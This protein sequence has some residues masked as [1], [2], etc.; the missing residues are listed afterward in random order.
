M[1][2]SLLLL[3]LA[4]CFSFDLLAQP[5]FIKQ[6]TLSSSE[7]N[8]VHLPGTGSSLLV[9][10]AATTTS[11]K[12]LA[13]TRLDS[14]GTVSG[15]T[16]WDGSNTQGAIFNVRPLA[17]GRLMACGYDFINFSDLYGLLVEIDATG[18]P[19]QAHHLGYNSV[20]RWADVVAT[21]D[22]GFIALG[23]GSVQS[24]IDIQSIFA[25]FDAQGDTVWTH[26]YGNSGYEYQLV[27]G[28]LLPQ[29]D[30]LAFGTSLVIGSNRYTLTAQSMSPS[31]HLRWAKRY[32]T[33]AYSLRPGAAVVH[34]DTVYLAFSVRD[35]SS[36]T[37]VETA[38]MLAMDTTG[39]VLWA[40]LLAGQDASFA[41]Q[42]G[43]T[44]SGEPI[45]VGGY[46]RGTDTYGL[47]AAFSSSGSLLW[48]S[49][50]GVGNTVNSILDTDDGYLLAIADELVSQVMHVARVGTQGQLSSNCDTEI[51]SWAPTPLGFTAVNLVQNSFGG[52]Y[53]P[54]ISMGN[55]SSSIS[56]ST[57]CGN[58]VAVPSVQEAAHAVLTPQPMYQV[59]QLRLPAGNRAGIQL[60]LHDLGGKALVP[61]VIP[62][63]DGLEIQRGGLP[64]GLYSYQVLQGGL[65]IASGK[66][67]IAD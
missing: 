8:L 19:Q 31:G 39:T 53:L 43:L 22:T 30:A 42:I 5:N 18:Q 61:S 49:G 10:S 2:K 41:R 12:P 52:C 33:G 7:F 11:V 60:L 36:F 59:A 6:Y 50:Y 37:T 28:A 14:Q 17:D 54:S 66:L 56:T 62:T 65:R 48:S 4:I 64:A 24:G 3:C 46:Q 45:L 23:M 26:V 25:K 20:A 55:T 27:A 38:G 32:D 21:P 13:F 29:G 15:Q 40:T 35:S 44:P 9:G 58:L 63:A 57:V 1:K 67:W 51:P 16:G 34:G 47:V